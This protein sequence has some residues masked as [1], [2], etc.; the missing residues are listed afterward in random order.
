MI[1]KEFSKRPLE[2]KKVC[3]SKLL[4]FAKRRWLNE[5]ESEGFTYAQ[6]FLD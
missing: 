5:V 6:T 4:P 3:Y 2:F 1:A